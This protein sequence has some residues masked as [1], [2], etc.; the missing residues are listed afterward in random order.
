[1]P[2]VSIRRHSF[3]SGPAVLY[4]VIESQL[5]VWIVGRT[6]YCTVACFLPFALGGS[7]RGVSSRPV[8]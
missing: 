7:G 6:Q 2:M 1:M 3:N 4:A 5:K 8:L